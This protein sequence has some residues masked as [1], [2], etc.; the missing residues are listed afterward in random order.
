MHQVYK[1][2]MELL[3]DMPELTYNEHFRAAYRRAAEL[4]S[5][6]DRLP[7]MQFVPDHL[8]KDNID[9]KDISS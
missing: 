3:D 8:R 5:E 1:E 4:A 9:G 7:P 6:D 2:L